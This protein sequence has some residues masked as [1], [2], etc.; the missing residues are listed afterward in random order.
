VQSRA[1]E[2]VLRAKVSERMQPGVVYTTFHWPGVRRQRGDHREF[3]LGHQLPGIQGDRR[4]GEP[5]VCR[6]VAA[7]RPPP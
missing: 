1:G 4:A 6:A 5:L 2:T 3:R 7:L